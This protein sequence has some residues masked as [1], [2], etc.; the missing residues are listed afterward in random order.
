MAPDECTQGVI[1]QL[2]ASTADRWLGE[3]DSRLAALDVIDGLGDSIH[4]NQKGKFDKQTHKTETKV[5]QQFEKLGIDEHL[6]MHDGDVQ[7]RIKNPR[8]YRSAGSWRG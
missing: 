8:H 7:Q 5:Q 3:G 6:D 4:V 2:D 1:S